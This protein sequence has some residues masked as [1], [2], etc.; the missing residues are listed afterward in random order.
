MRLTPR[1][2]ILILTPL[3]I[4]ASTAQ[5]DDWPQ[6]R[7][8]KRD[9]HSAETGLLTQWPEQGPKLLWSYEELGDGYAS[10]SIVGGKVYTTGVEDGSGYLFCFDTQGKLLWK[11]S[12]GP[13]WNGSYKGARSTPT[14][15]DGKVYVFSGH[16]TLACFDASSGQK[17]WSVD[18]MHLYRGRNIQWGLSQSVLV[19]GNMVICQV[20]GRNAAVVALN[21]ETGKTIWTSR[22]WSERSAYCSPVMIQRGK[23]Q[24][25]VT[26][27]EA[28]V[29][30][31]NPRSGQVM[32]K[33]P[34]K[35]RYSV[36]AN[37]PVHKNGLLYIACGYGWGSQV[38]QLSAD[39]ARA[40]QLWHQELQDTHHGGSVLIDNYV[41]ATSSNRPRN[42]WLCLD[43][44]TGREMWR[45]RGVGKGSVIAAD[46]MLY[47]YGERGKLALAR[48]TPKGLTT[49]S[50]FP[51]T[52]GGGKH[53]GH[54]AISNGVM[55]IR[56]GNALM[57]YDIKK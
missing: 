56:H 39:G 10:V 12:Y 32:W 23:R 49:V 16:G 51:I 22:G 47:C 27:T 25:L 26:A 36:S 35:N 1:A 54:P 29:I 20:G 14:V 44:R 7:G 15:H 3:L 33:I 17:A 2:L 45:A 34:M 38:I 9:G 40:K 5:G 8:P 18:V 42:Q 46:G 57:A 55:Y 41:Y 50:E 21:R 37:S 4:L 30:G 6:F 28:H 48:A 11:K 24:L 13:G 43:I 53:W 52:M 31:V 19:S